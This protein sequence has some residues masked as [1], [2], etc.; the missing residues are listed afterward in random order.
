[1][2]ASTLDARCSRTASLLSSRHQKERRERKHTGKQ[3]GGTF[4]LWP[5]TLKS[6]C[7]GAY[8]FV[9]RL[10]SHFR[11]VEWSPSSVIFT[12]HHTQPL[13]TAR[14]FSSSKHFGIPSPVPI[15]SSPTSYEPPSVISVASD[16]E[17][18]FAYF[19]RRDGDG[20]GCLWKRGAQIDSWTVKEWWSF[21][22]GAGVVAASW[23]GE[24]REVL[25]LR[26]DILRHLIYFLV[27]NRSFRYHDASTASWATYPDIK[28]Y[29][30]SC[31]TGSSCE[32]VL[33]ST[34]NYNI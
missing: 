3:A 27:V 33:L 18:L 1:V 17:W 13:V 24:G 20:I 25:E 26:L 22:H 14:H 5:N 8:S 15:V 19:P 6:T 4:S 31:N 29:N 9:L 23:L 34:S 16:D 28:P 10:S 11:P 32:C 30:T 2:S 7:H 12:A 21:A